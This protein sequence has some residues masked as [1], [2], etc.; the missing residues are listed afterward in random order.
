VK[1]EVVPFGKLIVG[2]IV[3]GAVVFGLGSRVAMRVVG[4]LASPEHAGEKTAF[5]T[6]GRITVAGVVGLIVFGAIAG[7]VAGFFYLAIRHWLP[8]NIVARG[9]LFGLLL[10]P[11][12]GIVIATSSKTDFDLASTTLV[13][14]LFAAMIVVDGLATAWVI[15]RLGR[16][17]LPPSHP[18]PLGYL[19][20][21]T[22]AVIGIVALF[23]PVREVL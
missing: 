7:L 17:S 22:I 18:R 1:E 5:G 19:I 11:P 20:L 2:A 15:E 9:L 4:I 6:V 12:V 14:S 13:F 8:T 21:G 23:D 16:G 10:I 3:V